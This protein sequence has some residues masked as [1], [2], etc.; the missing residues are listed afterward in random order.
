MNHVYATKSTDLCYT[1]VAL[2]TAAVLCG[3][4]SLLFENTRPTFPPF[5]FSVI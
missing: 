3:P 5:V 1:V 4:S 2:N